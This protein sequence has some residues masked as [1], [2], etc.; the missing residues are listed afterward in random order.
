AVG[1]CLIFLDS[2]H[3]ADELGTR[4][5]D[6]LAA[7]HTAADAPA[8]LRRIRGLLAYYRAGGRQ[9]PP[10]YQSFAVTG[11]V[12]YCTLLPVASTTEDTSAGQVAAI[13]GFLFAM[14]SLMLSLGH[15]RSQLELAVRQS[16][17]EEPAKTALLWAARCH[18][19]LMP[20]DQLRSRCADLLAN[21]L[22][23]PA[24]PRYLSGFVR[25]LDP[26]P[27]LAP[28]LVEIVS[29]AFAHLPEPVLLPWVPSVINTL[30]NQA[31]ALVSGLVREAGRTFPTTLDALDHWVP[32]WSNDSAAPVPDPAPVRDVSTLLTRYPATADALFALL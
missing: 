17:P 29:T 3:F 20:L 16:H 7:E 26:I 15:G 4:A 31:G 6:L 24:F 21:P 32:P 19:G 30:L 8:V 11:Y 1:D 27:A 18:L 28:F 23:V 12:Q 10:W 9:P 5:V 22:V 2:H 13:L 14:E 25:A